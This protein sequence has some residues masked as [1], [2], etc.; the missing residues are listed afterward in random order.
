[1]PENTENEYELYADA[2]KEVKS[3]FQHFDLC[4]PEEHDLLIIAQQAIGYVTSDEEVL[5][6]YGERGDFEDPVFSLMFDNAAVLMMAGYLRNEMERIQQSPVAVLWN[7]MALQYV[8]FQMTKT[9]D[10]EDPGSYFDPRS[11]DV[12]RLRIGDG[13]RSKIARFYLFADR[14]SSMHDRIME[15]GL[16]FYDAACTADEMREDAGLSAEPGVPKS[17]MEWSASAP[18]M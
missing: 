11:W 4:V 6:E 12:S 1:M 9:A 8:D 16:S 10:G 3:L 2:I 13:E 7:D 15:S 18:E 17:V 14:V 5:D